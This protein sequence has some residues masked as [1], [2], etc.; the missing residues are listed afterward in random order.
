MSTDKVLLRQ[1]HPF[2]CISSVAAFKIQGESWVLATEHM[3]HKAKNIS[4]LA[5]YGKRLL[6]P[7]EN[8]RSQTSLQ[9]GGT[10]C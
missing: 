1:S 5:L 7:D 4:Y 3:A 8:H 6:T 10:L 9:L 2:I